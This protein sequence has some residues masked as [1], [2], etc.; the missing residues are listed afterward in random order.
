MTA[1]D[2]INDRYGRGT[3]AMASARDGQDPDALGYEA[4]ASHTAVHDLLG[5]GAGGKGVRPV[6]YSEAGGLAQTLAV[7]YEVMP[8]VFERSSLPARAL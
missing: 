5:G 8:T 2:R 3:L 6:R 4:G 7:H 1:L